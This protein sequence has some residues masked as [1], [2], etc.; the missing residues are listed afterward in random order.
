MARFLRKARVVIGIT[1]ACI[2]AG[3]TAGILCALVLAPLLGGPGG[4][5]YTRIFGVAAAVGATCGLALGPAAMFGFLRRVP[6]GRLF[7]EIIIGTTLGGLLGIPFGSLPVAVI[8]FAAAVGHLAY[9]FRAKAE[10]PQV[11]SD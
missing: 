1:V 8:G 4:L 9:R 10:P 5:S 2:A 7:S 3:A 11:L 6:L